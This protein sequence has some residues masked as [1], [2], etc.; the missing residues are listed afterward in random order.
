IRRLELEGIDLQ[1]HEIQVPTLLHHR[2]DGARAMA[3][4]DS[5]PII[6]QQHALHHGSRRTLPICSSDGNT[7]TLGLLKTKFQLSN[8]RNSL[9]SKGANERITWPHR[10]T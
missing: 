4:E 9:V 10:R 3:S 2:T 1:N 7:E 8:D 5:S 6:R